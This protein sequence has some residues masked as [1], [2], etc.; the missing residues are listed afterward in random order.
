MQRSVNIVAKQVLDIVPVN[1]ELYIQINKFIENLWNQAPETLFSEYNWKK[2]IQVLNMYVQ[3][4]ELG[5]Q[6]Q[7]ILNGLPSK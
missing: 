1:S 7:E 4:Q 6:I 5:K 2:F 3:D